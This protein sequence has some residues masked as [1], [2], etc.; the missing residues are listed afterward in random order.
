MEKKLFIAYQS[1]E[2]VEKIWDRQE[3]NNRIKILKDEE[4]YWMA[5]P[6]GPDWCETVV[7]ILE[8]IGNA[9]ALV[10]FFSDSYWRLD[11]RKW[12]KSIADRHRY[13]QD[14]VE[15]NPVELI[16]GSLDDKDT[17]FLVS[18]DS[19]KFVDI[20]WPIY[21]IKGYPIERFHLMGR[22]VAPA[23]FCNEDAKE[24]YYHFLRC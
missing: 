15:V 2:I 20:F 21:A 7:G 23:L 9:D 13:G 8:T 4:R 14:A 18:V 19:I 5:I 24:E 11:K 1:F 22:N 3:A 12:L 17:M 10:V 6:I 16:D